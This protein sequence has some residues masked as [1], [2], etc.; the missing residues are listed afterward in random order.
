[1]EHELLGKGVYAIINKSLN[2]IYVGETERNF[3]IRWIEHLMRIPNFIGDPKRIHLYL[4]NST[5]FIILK[6]MDDLEFKR[7]DFYRLEYDARNFYI[8]KGWEVLSSHNYNPNAEYEKHESSE[9]L[10][11]RYRKAIKHMAY[12]LAAVNTKHTNGSYILSSSY[13]KVD[14]QFNTNLNNREGKNTLHKLTREELEFIMLELYP[15][16]YHKSLD[17]FRKEFKHVKVPD[18][19]FTL[20]D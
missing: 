13:K 12:V 8:Q 6:K 3:L 16:F 20:S 2:S 7:G 9:S 18:D 15:R 1:M 4:N 10:L 17:L 19:L 14:K 5:R 11:D